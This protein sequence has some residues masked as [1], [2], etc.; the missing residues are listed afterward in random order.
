MAEKTQEDY[1]LERIAGGDQ[2]ALGE[3]FL[4]HQERLEIIVRFRMDPRLQGR[5][6][7]GDVVQES[8]LE[9]TRRIDYYFSN[10]KTTFFLWLRYLTLQKLNELHR[11]HF[12]VKA[13]DKNREVSI[14]KR[15]D[16]PATTAQIAHVLFDDQTS[17]SAAMLRDEA[18]LVIENALGVMDPVDQ[19]IL[20]LRHFEKLSNVEVAESLSLNESTA[21]KR[22]VRALQK[23]KAI[24]GEYEID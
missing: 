15:I 13:R 2:A 22:F 16:S 6:D 11:H 21:S 19:E 12:G 1:L 8:L 23:L 7:S 20:A 17:P 4:Q 24:V 10:R 3:I 18:R 9:A 5:L 14:F